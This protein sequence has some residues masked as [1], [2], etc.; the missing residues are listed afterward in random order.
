LRWH[1]VP[2]I[3]NMR[4]SIGGVDY[5]LAPFSGWYMGSEI[6]S[7]NLADTD[8]Y[9]Q[10]PVIAQKMGLDMTRESTLWRDRALVELNRAVLF[11][12]DKAGVRMTDHH[13]ESRL[14]LTHIERELHAG[15]PTP[16]DWTWIVPP[17][18]G[19]ITS[20]FHRYYVEADLRPNFYLDAPAQAYI[21]G[22]DVCPVA[23]ATPSPVAPAPQRR[24]WRGLL[25][26]RRGEL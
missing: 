4:L 20:V 18:S 3:A 8:R 22:A 1:A 14:F 13:T 12:F 19:G 9:D 11:S 5:P 21:T 2:A 15:R 17:I 24:G 26:R 25:D 23:H 7:R 6:G 16:A 10:I